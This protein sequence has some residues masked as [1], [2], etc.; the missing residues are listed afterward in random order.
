MLG[1]QGVQFAANA[2]FDGELSA[3]GSNTHDS[4]NITSL[5]RRTVPYVPLTLIIT[6]VGT[7]RVV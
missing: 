7:R 6:Y 5:D 3:S 4:L 1:Q 2:S